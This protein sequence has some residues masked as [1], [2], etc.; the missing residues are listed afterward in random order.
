MFFFIQK[1]GWA[2]LVAKDLMSRHSHVSTVHL[3]LEEFPWDRIKMEGKEHNHAFQ[4]SVS[5]IRVCNL[6][7]SKTGKPSFY[8]GFKDLEVMKS[9]QS[10]F[11]NFVRDEY[12]SLP[13]TKDRVFCTKMKCKYTFNR[14]EGVD[15]TKIYER[16]KQIAVETF[17][18]NPQ[19]G[20]YSPSVQ[21]TLYM[22]GEKA[23]QEI[24]ELETIFFSLPNVHFYPV[25]FKNWKTNL[26]NKNEV[27]Q[28]Y[29]GPN[30]LIQA[31]IVR[32]AKSKL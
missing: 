8:S 19:A 28:T 2:F 12:T 25:D 29:D 20:T 6:K 23:L 22:A 7:I 10:G 5:G 15:F 16:V 32:Q 3:K 26:E 4:R 13:E 27:F 21:Q 30:G 9:T 1:K 11:E 31:K 17:A 18:G 24:P 14:L